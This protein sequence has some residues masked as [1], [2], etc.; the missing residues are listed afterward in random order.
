MFLY[1]CNA[2]FPVL[3]EGSELLVP[4]SRTTT[5][6]GVPVEGYERMSAPVPNATEACFEHEV[7]TEPDGSVPV[8]LVNRALGLGVYQ[9]GAQVRRSARCHRGRERMPGGHAGD[10]GLA[11][12]ELCAILGSDVGIKHR[13]SV[14]EQLLGGTQVFRARHPV[15][16][17][18]AVAESP[19]DQASL[20]PHEGSAAR[21]GL[22]QALFH[23]D[24]NGAAH[25]PNCQAGL[26]GQIRD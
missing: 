14:L 11:L 7:V 10:G 6:Y 15:L 2:G 12:N 9:V 25:S 23:Q 4:S 5:D 21:H 19:D 1:P 3:D 13:G 17:L 22:Y 16:A 26:R 24:V 20:S 18:S 8:A